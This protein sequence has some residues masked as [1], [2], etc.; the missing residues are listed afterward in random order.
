MR[1][2]QY[3]MMWRIEIGRYVLH[4]LACAGLAYFTLLLFFN[5]LHALVLEPV[6]LPL[7][8]EHW[9]YGCIMIAS[10]L[11]DIIYA[12][13]SSLSKISLAVLYTVLGFLT[14]FYLFINQVGNP[15]FGGVMGIGC[16]LIF[17]AGIIAIPRESLLT[18][19]MAWLIPILG[20]ILL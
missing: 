2:K 4:K 20:Q 12:R 3:P 15:W 11:G 8:P 1:A 14:G 9:I 16:I 17:Y 18:P 6:I 13:F 19:F 10:F 7:S 5:V